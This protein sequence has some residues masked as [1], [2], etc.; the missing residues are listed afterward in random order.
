MSQTPRTWLDPIN[1][2]P[3]KRENN[4][5]VSDDG[6]HSYPIVNNIPRFVS[7]DNYASS[8]GKQWIMFSKT[9]LD[10]HTG[11]KLSEDR[12]RRCLNG[13]IDSLKGKKVLEA[14]SGAGRFTEI[15]L[16]KGAELDSFDYSTAVEANYK[17]NGNHPDLRL[18]QADVREMPFPSN[19]Y[20]V[21]VCLGVVQHTPSPEQTIE[22]LWSRVRPGGTLVFDHYRKKIRN[23]LP[24]PIGVGNML[25]R[26]YFLSLPAE[27]RF[28]AV[29]R[30]F[31]FWFPIVWRYR[32][33]KIF[34]F[35]IARFN[36]IVNYYPHF[37]L[38]DKEMYYDWM[39]LDTH[40]ATTDTFKHRRT[41]HE[42]ETLL[43]SLGATNI[44]V[45]NAGNG[46]EAFCQKSD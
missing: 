1:N 35:F 6:Q 15:L 30:V 7:L 14:G 20:D 5:L 22:A 19:H 13:T 41:T 18:A 9:Q 40:D 29:K 16:Q 4:Q 34:Q 44:K 12:L 25:Y 10:S 32:K 33:N 8:F 46:I 45:V 21:V 27:K 39:L 17:N 31:D 3:L 42:I 11:L 24:P 37:G 2:H 38:K 23:Y 36:P 28:D 43:K 26:L